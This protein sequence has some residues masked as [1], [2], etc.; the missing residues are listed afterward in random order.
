MSEEKPREDLQTLWEEYEL[1]VE[2]SRGHNF[3]TQ[4]LLNLREKWEPII[5][6]WQLHSFA[7]SGVIDYLLDGE[8]RPAKEAFAELMINYKEWREKAEKWDN[9][10]C[11]VIDICP[12]LEEAREKLRKI[13]EFISILE[14]SMIDNEEILELSP[15][16]PLIV[17]TRERQTIALRLQAILRGESS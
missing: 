5:H 4:D 13:E 17:K 1:I 15:D 11:S 6:K 8:Y 3:F 7:L 16:E 14:E 10:V 12:N 9:G 2:L